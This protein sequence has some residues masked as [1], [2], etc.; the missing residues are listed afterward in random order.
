[1]RYAT[2]GRDG[3][4]KIWNG[5]TMQNELTIKVTKSSSKDKTKTIWVTCICYM[6]FSK[7]LVAASANRMISFYD[8][9]ENKNK[10][11]D[12]I[13]PSSR[14]EGLVGIPLCLDYHY[15]NNKASNIDGKF[16]TLLMGDDLGICHKYDITLEDWHTCEYKVGT[17]DPMVCHFKKIDDDY[18]KEIKDEFEKQENKKKHNMQHLGIDQRGN[19][20]ERRN[21]SFGGNQVKHATSYS[22]KKPIAYKKIEVGITK[23]QRMI[24]KGWITMIKYYPELNYIISSSLDGFIHIHDIEKLE[25]KEGKTFNLHQKGVNAFVYSYKHRI[26]ASCGEERHIL[27]WDPHTIGVLSY[28]YGHN[29]SV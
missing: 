7:R 13:T 11:A 15:Y 12:K 20:H 3:R 24:H 17:N 22:Y 27:M 29:T 18:K 6:T 21:S 5:L 28:L 2:A 9:N 25:Y 16:E 8:L 10:S 14:I 19:N 1:M 23:M 26:V 4:V